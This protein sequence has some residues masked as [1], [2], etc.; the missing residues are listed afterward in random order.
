MDGRVSFNLRKQEMTI[1]MPTATF[2]D[3]WNNKTGRE[4]AIQEAYTNLGHEELFTIALKNNMII[5]SLE[6]VPNKY[7][8][9]PNLINPNTNSVLI[10][11]NVRDNSIEYS[12]WVCED[13]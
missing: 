8:F 12:S 4:M 7:N 11:F 2:M 6:Q 1:N 5:N 9:S 3:L 13:D 10:K